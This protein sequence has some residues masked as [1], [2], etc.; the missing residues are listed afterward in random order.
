MTRYVRGKTHENAA[1]MAI[2]AM[3]K[4]RK[5]FIIQENQKDLLANKGKISGN[6][7]RITP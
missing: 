4:E 2:H 5:D 1:L 7:P 3:L 6:F